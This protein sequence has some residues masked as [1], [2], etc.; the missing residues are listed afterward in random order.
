[1]KLN[2]E[3]LDV[4]KLARELVKEIYSLV[5]S[6]PKGEE[7]A[8]VLQ[9]KRAVISVC[10]NIAEGSGRGSKKEFKRFLR[11]AIGSLIEMRTSLLLAVDLG[12]LNKGD[13]EVIDQKVE[14]LYFKLFG[15]I[16]SLNA[17]SDFNASNG[18]GR[19]LI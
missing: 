15:L 17:S 19:S 1:M 6:F 4:W 10:L 5:E 3:N 11:V 16:K 7:F 12:Y 14:K 18:S 2:Y 9:I 13:L 8:L